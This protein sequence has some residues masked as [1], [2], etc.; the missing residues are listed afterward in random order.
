MHKCE[1]KKLYSLEL[2]NNEGEAEVF[3][4]AVEGKLSSEE[5]IFEGD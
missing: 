5:L 2:I 3:H 4:E 1:K